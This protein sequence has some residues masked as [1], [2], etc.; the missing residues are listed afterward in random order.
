M[1]KYSLDV[2]QM[3]SACWLLLF[4]TMLKDSVKQQQKIES[5]KV[6]LSKKKKKKRKDECSD[7]DNKKVRSPFTI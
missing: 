6:D 7:L 2:V 1:I 3:K 4:S 5:K